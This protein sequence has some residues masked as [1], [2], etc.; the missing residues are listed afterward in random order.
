MVA[1]RTIPIEESLRLAAVPLNLLQPS[2]SELVTT[3]LANF[4]EIL[5]HRPNFLELVVQFSGFS[6]V[7]SIQ[8]QLQHEK[9]FGNTGI[10]ILQVAKSLLCRPQAS[11]NTIFGMDVSEL[12]PTNLSIPVAS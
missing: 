7:T 8:A 2:I 5:T 6:L 11:M 12:I 3:Y 10:C 1:S 9:T 4:P